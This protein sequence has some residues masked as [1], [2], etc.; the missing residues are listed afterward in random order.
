MI[1]IAF[2]SLKQWPKRPTPAHQRKRSPFHSKYSDTL[3]DLEREL[4]QLSAKA[5]V[6]EADCEESEIRRDG[7]LRA[8]ARLRGPGI[9]LRFESKHGAKTFPCDTF[10]DWQDNLRAIALALEAL[11]KIDRYGV[12]SSGEQ[13]RGFAALPDKSRDN[14]FA[15]SMAA[16][17]WLKQH[18]GIEIGEQPPWPVEIKTIIRRAAIGAFHPDRQNGS[19]AMWKFWQQAASLLGIEI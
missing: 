5:I 12:T 14:I 9:V 19:D 7:N 4:A 16:A 10:T 17:L 8:D 2:R 13:Y 6:I 1:E 3:R 18:L 11:R 15:D